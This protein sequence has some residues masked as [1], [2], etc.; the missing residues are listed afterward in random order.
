MSSR[1]ITTI[2]LLAGQTPLVICHC[3]L[4]VPTEIFVNA[5]EGEVGFEIETVPLIRDHDAI[6]IAGI[7]A[8]KV[9]VVAQI[10]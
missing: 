5:D 6:P 7:F 10:V 9:V 3:K 4:C 8:A 1:W 2:A